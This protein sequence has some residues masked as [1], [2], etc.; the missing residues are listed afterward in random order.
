MNNFQRNS[1][2]LELCENIGN[3][4]DRLKFD[5]RF[6]IGASRKHV[7]NH[8][9][10]NS[11]E[12]FCFDKNQH[13]ESLQISILARK[14]SMNVLN[15][16]IRAYLEAGLISKWINDMKRKR[17]VN[18]PSDDNYIKVEHFGAVMLFVVVLFESLSIGCLMLE[19]LVYRKFSLLQRLR[20]NDALE[21]F[22][23]GKRHL[24]LD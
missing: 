15:R 10:Y 3:C 6:A 24:L 7:T 5:D 17:V 11:E 16:E 2:K 13:I 9:N 12:I 18:E 1:I 22:L 19:L 8:F 4:L 20:L 21:H 23:D 14:D